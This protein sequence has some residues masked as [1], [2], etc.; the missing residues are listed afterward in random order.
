MIKRKLRIKMLAAF[1]DALL[2]ETTNAVI[3]ACK[4]GTSYILGSDLMRGG[5]VVFPS[6]RFTVN[7]PR[8]DQELMHRSVQAGKGE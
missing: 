6:G 3:L 2:Y 8:C 1:F 4:T 7:V 5:G